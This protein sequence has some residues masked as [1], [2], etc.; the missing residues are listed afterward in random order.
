MQINVNL[1]EVKEVVDPGWYP[2]RIVG[3]DIKDTKKGDSQYINWELEIFDS[4][5]EFDGKKQFLNTS[6]KPNALPMLKRFLEAAGF[7][8]DSEGFNTEDVMGL[9]LEVQVE[10]DEYNGRPTNNVISYRPL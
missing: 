2:V 9:E 7:S 5:T 4:G 1:D 3:S 6:L 8:W 10:V